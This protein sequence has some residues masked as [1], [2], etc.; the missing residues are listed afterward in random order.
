MRAIR[1][2]LA[3]LLAITPGLSALAQEAPKFSL[4]I[5]CEPHKT[6]F[7]QSYPDHDAGPDFR[8]Y[9]CG[10][11]TYD[12]HKGT[13]F[14]LLSATAAAK[15]VPVMASADGVIKGMRDG[16]DDFLIP[17]NAHSLVA[18]RECGNGVVIDHGGGLET[19]YCHMKKGSLQVKKGD[20]V[21]RGQRLGDVGYSGLAEFAHVHFEVRKD[22]KVLDPFTGREQA[23]ACE[24]VPQTTATLWMPDV[25]AAFPSANSEIID[26]IF[27]ARV[28]TASELEADDQPPRPDGQSSELYFVARIA[29][30][31]RGDTV[32]VVLTGPSN[33]NYS[34]TSQPL[35]RDRGMHLAFGS[36]KTGASGH[37]PEGV[38]AGKIELLR[39][40]KV[41]G[42]RSGDI[43]IK[44]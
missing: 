12:G 26:A 36:A 40:A 42:E 15:G 11:T 1:S 19:Q 9:A 17:D 37:L 21:T 34:S 16:M 8:D 4:P 31:R 38:Y 13:D 29:N 44:K 35:Q 41:I 23:N 10:T 24:M 14:R 20:A 30:I 5:S 7:I 28:P 27:A 22:G 25:S 32:R 39:D 18:N 33:F 6:C 2:R 3:M 43:T